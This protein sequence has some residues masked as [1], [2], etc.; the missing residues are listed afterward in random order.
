MKCNEKQSQCECHPAR[1]PSGA[2][3]FASVLEAPAASASDLPTGQPVE[4]R[5]LMRRVASLAAI[6]LPLLGLIAAIIL[7]WGP[8]FG[9]LY[10]GLLIGGYVVSNIGICV[11]FHR[12]FTHKSFQTGPVVKALLGVFGSMAVEGSIIQWVST[13]RRH[14]QHSDRPDDPHSPHNHGVS[15][16]GGRSLW[17]RFRGFLHAHMGWFFMPDAPGLE[18]YVPDLTA[19]PL[20]RRISNLF[21]LWVLLSFAIPTAIAFAV[22]GTWMGALLGLLWGGA[23][24]VFLVH[25]ITWSINSVCHLWGSRPFDSH[26]HS[27]NNA[28]FGILAFGEGWHNNHHAFPTSA[29]HGLRWW[30]FDASYWIIRG[31]ELVGLA[32]AVRVPSPERIEAKRRGRP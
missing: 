12:Y 19:D 16:E 26:D 29:R 8:G 3:P 25:H 17:S 15:A 28:I 30:E 9:W 18:K 6:T 24:R 31:M 21:P 7:L 5:S 13:H 4:D 14:H 11:G 20:T 32:R 23:V 10:L 2:Q 22:T 27:R 1:G